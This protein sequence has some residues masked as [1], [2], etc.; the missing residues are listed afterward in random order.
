M[1][2]KGTEEVSL[3]C[4][5]GV[6]IKFQSTLN[7]KVSSITFI[8]CA[9]N[10]IENIDQFRLEDSI[11]TFLNNTP[12]LALTV[13]K[14]SVL[15][16]R[17]SFLHIHPTGSVRNTSSY[18]KMYHYP[19]NFYGVII[20]LDS[21][22]VILDSTFKGSKAG[23]IG[24]AIY[25][26]RNDLVITR[27]NFSYYKRAC[28]YQCFG[29][30][31]FAV[32]S[33]VATSVSNFIGNEISYKF[34]RCRG[35]SITRGG[36]L[37]F[38]DSRVT[39]D[40]TN[41]FDNSACTGGAVY[42]LRGMVSI[43][44]VNFMQ[45]RAFSTGSGVSTIAASV[46]I[47]NCNFTFNFASKE[48]TLSIVRS[49]I[50]VN[51][52][53]FYRNVAGI[54]GGAIKTTNKTIIIVTQSMILENKANYTG[55]G[56][57]AT[58]NSTL[59]LERSIL[60]HNL[61]RKAGGGIKAHHDS[62]LL[63][64]DKVII[65]NNVAYYGGAIH[66]QFTRFKSNGTLIIANNSAALGIVAFL[67][68][69]GCL[70]ENITLEHNTGSLFVFNS[71]VKGDGDIH[72][73]H[74][75]QSQNFIVNPEV[76]EGGGL[77]CILG[78]IDL[79]GKVLV[80]HNGASNGGAILAVTSRV[81]LEGRVILSSNSATMTGGA[82]YVYHG[83]IVIAGC[84]LI[85]D[86]VGIYR[87]GGIH[88]VSSSLILVH[89]DIEG[90]LPAY[91]YLMSNTAQLGGG[92]CLEV[93]SKIYLITTKRLMHFI[94]NKADYGGGI[95]IADE[96]NNGT[97]TSS[98]DTVT[99][100]SESECFFQSVTPRNRLMTI[101]ESISFSNNAA[102]FS[103][104]VLYGGLLDRCTVN[105]LTNRHI[106]YSY[107]PGFMDNIHNF[108]NSD[109]VRVCFCKNSIADCSYHPGSI[110]VMK[111]REFSI[112]LVEVDQTNNSLSGKV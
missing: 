50:I 74:N 89:D 29:G 67:Y 22:L 51:N 92:V 33:R 31:V 58:H 34:N 28:E 21:T 104:S 110:K 57:Y 85:T 16:R 66:M 96:T 44:N 76:Q 99:A 68:S 11:F 69:S 25:A 45:N 36:A 84:T 79:S 3:S 83:E 38:V 6:S 40:Q 87:G 17:T 73:A 30:A 90:A 7:I 91:L 93:S 64:S 82:I 60:K 94:S 47:N 46:Y 56:I 1:Q 103:G 18:T 13:T 54:N 101:N 65:K 10:P 102:K 78:R 4:A 61:A 39:I 35:S 72:I 59:V 98:L 108:T 81:T 24:G 9:A 15:I 27:C 42:T 8:G 97:C 52:S 105:A 41:F 26:E 80:E 55:G 77:T 37:G 63:F 14:S 100:A 106:R 12:G 107:L 19:E 49:D 109:A 75:K 53:N 43:L 112:E 48:G 71:Y 62:K 23:F 20:S 86:N 111:G 88:S 95:Y 5:E 70:N 32:D 2:S